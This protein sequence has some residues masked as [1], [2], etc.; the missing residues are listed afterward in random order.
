M[1][2]SWRTW[3][4]IGLT[5][6]A[7]LIAPGSG[8]FGEEPLTADQLRFEQSIGPL[9]A[10]KCLSC[11][12]GTESKGGLDLTR[13][14]KLLAGG[15][16]GPALEPGNLEKSLVWQR[17]SADEM[18]PKNPLSAAEKLVIKVWIKAGAAWSGGGLDPLRISTD[19]RA[20]YDW[21]SLQ[22]IQR[23][24]I[25]ETGAASR[26]RQ[27]VDEFVHAK[28]GLPRIAARCAGRSPRCD[29]SSDV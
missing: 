3:I 1:A 13:R 20:G 24:A 19:Q 12:A 7:G 25:P 29:P 21:W 17:I 27:P 15:D 23:P 2:V 26:A 4:C 8:V 6:L 9:I 10:A 22:T 28:F 18:P 14:E 11:H 16:S 5:C